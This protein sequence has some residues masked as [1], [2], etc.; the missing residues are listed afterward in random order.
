MQET[1]GHPP[2]IVGIG[3]TLRQGST[4]E[5]ALRVALGFAAQRGA[6]TRAFTG[7]AVNLSPYDP[8]HPRRSVEATALVEALRA[9][10]GVIIA[11]P[12]YH[13]SISGL[14]KNAVD[15]AE[16]LRDDPRPYLSDRGVGLIVC[17]DGVQA[18]GSTLASLRALA[19]ALR[20]WPT[21]YGAVIHAAAQPF[22]ADGRCRST[23]VAEQL[24]RVAEQVVDMAVMQ[25]RRVIG[26]HGP[27]PHP[28]AADPPSPAANGINSTVQGGTP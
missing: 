23:E 17:A 11:S 21:P 7:P 1:P 2:L 4:S 5:R 12:S 3:G 27:R 26:G 16:D 9:A 14:L 28:P 18:M 22:S 6:A 8:A 24:R 19:H 20:G 10:D 25:H 15:Y 13:G